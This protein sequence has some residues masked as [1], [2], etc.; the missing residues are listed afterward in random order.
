MHMKYKIPTI[1]DLKPGLEY[2][3]FIPAGTH[4]IISIDFATDE[5]KTIAESDDEWVPRKF[6]KIN[7]PMKYKC[8]DIEVED[9]FSPM[10]YEVGL[11]SE[12]KSLI[13]KGWIRIKSV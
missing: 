4:S 10:I 13:N 11:I 6:P 5:I 12:L 1:E 3:E 7:F 9:M 8:G 2:E